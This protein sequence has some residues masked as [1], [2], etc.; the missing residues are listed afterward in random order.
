[1][2]RKLAYTARALEAPVA[3]DHT[4]AYWTSAKIGERVGSESK[5]LAPSAGRV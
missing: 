2:E 5:T 4:P 3:V 1:M